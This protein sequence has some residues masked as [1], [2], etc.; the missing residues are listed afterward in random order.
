MDCLRGTWPPRLNAMV[1]NFAVWRKLSSKNAQV[2][3][4]E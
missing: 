4:M 3:D 1:N 2:V